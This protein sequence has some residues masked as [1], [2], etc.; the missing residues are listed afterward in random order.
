MPAREGPIARRGGGFGRVT[1]PPE[2]PV[3]EVAN[4]RLDHAIER[5]REQPNLPNRETELLIQRQPERMAV[6]LVT[7]EHALDP[8]AR[9][10]AVVDL[11]VPAHDLGIAEERGEEVEIVE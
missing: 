3:D 6:T 11:G 7:R 1:A 4:L 10:V 8:A 5:L 2:R 9:L